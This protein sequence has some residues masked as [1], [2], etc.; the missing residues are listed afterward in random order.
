MAMQSYNT[1]MS[2]NRMNAAGLI[3]REMMKEGPKM[4]TKKKATPKK[5]AAPVKKKGKK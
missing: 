3:G 2:R 4:A 5:A 1:A